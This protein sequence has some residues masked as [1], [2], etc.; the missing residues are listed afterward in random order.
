ML[1][2]S[3]QIV[4]FQE[5]YLTDMNVNANL[6][7]WVKDFLTCKPHVKFNSIKYDVII[8]NKGARKDVCYP[9]YCLPYE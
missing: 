6:K 9:P 1:G 5:A 3:D 2:I 7:L 4:Y 8:T